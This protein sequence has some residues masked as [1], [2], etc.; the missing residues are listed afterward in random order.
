[1][2]VLSL[3]VVEKVVLVGAR[4]NCD[5]KIVG[6]GQDDAAIDTKEVSPHT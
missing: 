1:M 5:D 4:Q 3:T 6:L 2:R